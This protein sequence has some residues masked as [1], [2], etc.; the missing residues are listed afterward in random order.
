VAQ[1]DV[2]SNP[3]ASRARIPYLLDIQSDLVDLATRV[4]VPLVKLSVFGPVITRLNP[5]MTINTDEFVLSTGDLASVPK[6][7]LRAPIVNMGNERDQ[8]MAAIDLLITGI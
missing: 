8:I 1:F 2:Y 3:R 5:I 7:D 6:S 4:V